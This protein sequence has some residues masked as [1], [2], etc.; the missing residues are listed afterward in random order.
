MIHYSCDRCKCQLD[1]HDDL[2]Y[3]VKIEI[4]AMMDPIA[5]PEPEAD[6]DH[7]LEIE[8]ILEQLAEEESCDVGED[9]YQKRSFDLCPNCYRKFIQN[10]L[11][12]EQKTAVGF[13]KN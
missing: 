13:S 3:C 5:D 11:G 1:P 10:P 12:R 7:L 2:R 4:Q 9:I 6:R 8:D